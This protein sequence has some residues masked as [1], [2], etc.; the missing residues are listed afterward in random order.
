LPSLTLG[1]L[2]KKGYKIV[3][4]TSKATLPISQS[5]LEM[6]VNAR[7]YGHCSCVSERACV[8]VCAFSCLAGVTHTPR[9]LLSGSKQITCREGTA[10]HLWPVA[11]G[12]V[13]VARDELKSCG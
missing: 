13:K 9:G 8:R 12:K 4:A 5:R 11:A 2:P 3:C 10:P 7:I 6:E 1:S